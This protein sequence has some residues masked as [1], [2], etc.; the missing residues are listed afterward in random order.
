[1]KKLV[2]ACALLM[3]SLLLSSCQLP[4]SGAKK[5]G[6]KN[7]IEKTLIDSGENIRVETWSTGSSKVNLETP[8]NGRSPRASCTVDARKT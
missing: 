3:A 2:P 5:M 8:T 1:M 6:S 4:E 7:A